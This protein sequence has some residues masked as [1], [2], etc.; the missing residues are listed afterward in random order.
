MFARYGETAS[1]F[2]KNLDRILLRKFYLAVVRGKFPEGEID[3]KM[4]LRE[5]PSDPIRLRMH[6]HDD[7]KECWT[8]FKLVRRLDC[9][10]I[11]PDLSLVE[12]ELMTSRKHQIRAHLAE[13]GFPIVGDRLYY[14]DGTYY[15]KLAQGG[16]L[17]DDDFKVLGA[18][19]QCRQLHLRVYR[20]V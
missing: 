17:S 3:C 10:E 18:H 8:R 15:E 16:E 1:R 9:P 6:H 7:G 14:R 5:D 11:A 13:M 12:A 20:L 19:S 2:Q 4:P